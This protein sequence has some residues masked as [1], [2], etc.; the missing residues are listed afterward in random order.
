MSNSIQQ[1]PGRISEGQT[2]TTLTQALDNLG[3]SSHSASIVQSHGPSNN[4]YLIHQAGNGSCNDWS[5]QRFDG[6]ISD[7]QNDIR[8]F[9]DGLGKRAASAKIVEELGG[10][11]YSH[12]FFETQ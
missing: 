3:S 2:A 1:F 4:V 8:N 10:T 5:V 11:N 7:N 9:L 12:V 6:R